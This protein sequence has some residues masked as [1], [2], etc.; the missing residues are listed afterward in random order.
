MRA[1]S[2]YTYIVYLVPHLNLQH[3]IAVKLVN[4][5]YITSSIKLQDELK[6]GFSNCGTRT[7]TG[8][9]S[10]VYWYHAAALLTAN[11]P[12]QQDTT[13]HAAI[14]SLTFLMIYKC[15]SETC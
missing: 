9:A 14:C 7:I 13:P 6:Y 15:L 12:L 11:P 1:V 8:T 10:I 3:S 2:C 4:T 5:K